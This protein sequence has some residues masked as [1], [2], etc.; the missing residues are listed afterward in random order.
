MSV[1]YR[2]TIRVSESTMKKLEQ[3]VESYHYESVSDVIRKAID[4]LIERDYKDQGIEHLNVTVSRSLLD[5]LNI[6]ME[7]E[8]TLPLEDIIKA[9]LREYTSREMKKEMKELMD[10]LK[11]KDS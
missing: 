3:L 1:P 10:E 6:K 2:I 8:E 4:V 9:A 7:T 5:E 11:E